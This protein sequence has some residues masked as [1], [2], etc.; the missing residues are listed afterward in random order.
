VHRVRVIGDIDVPVRQLLA[1]S[2][3]PRTGCPQGRRERSDLL[4][5]IRGSSDERL[6]KTLAAGCVESRKDLTAT[7]VKNG[8]TSGAPFPRNGGQRR[9]GAGRLL[10]EGTAERIQGADATDGHSRAGSQ[11]P[12]RRQPD[13]DADERPR[14]AA[15]ADPSHLLPAAARLRRALYLGEQGGRVLRASVSRQAER[16]LMQHLAAAHRADGGVG[17]RR[18]ETDDRLLLGAQ[19]S[20]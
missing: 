12:G 4:G 5:E 11:T 9:T 7:G 6:P 3:R 18:V 17:A 15:D 19:L 10:A 2:Y 13:P 8:Q 20:Q 16:R 1:K 14:P